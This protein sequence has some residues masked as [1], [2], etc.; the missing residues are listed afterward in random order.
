MEGCKNVGDRL[1]FR[2]GIKPVFTFLHTPGVC[3]CVSVTFEKHSCFQEIH[4]LQSKKTDVGELEKEREEAVQRLQVSLLGQ[5]VPP[6][7]LWQT[8]TGIQTFT[9]A[10]TQQKGSQYVRLGSPEPCSGFQPLSASAGWF[11]M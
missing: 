6:A 9:T 8:L 4:T 2:N 10:T 3:A 11:Y 5:L 1:I 7:A